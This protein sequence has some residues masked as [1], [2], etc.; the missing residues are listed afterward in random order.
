MLSEDEII[1]FNSLS[2]V[3]D[4]L[5]FLH[6]F[7]HVKTNVQS[8]H[9]LWNRYVLSPFSL[10]RSLTNLTSDRDPQFVRGDAQGESN[11]RSG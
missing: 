3:H 4:H 1:G 2:G 9:C 8:H 7:S 5:A 10:S 11:R 6:S